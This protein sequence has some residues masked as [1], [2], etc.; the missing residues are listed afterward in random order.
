ME[1]ATLLKARAAADRLLAVRPRS[2]Q[3]LRQRLERRGFPD[4]IVET[5]VQ[6]LTRQGL[7]NDPQFARYV[8][9]SRLL[10]KPV[11][12]RR[13]REQ[14]RRT[15]VP[16]AVAEQ[17]VRAATEGYDEAE[18]ARALAVRRWASLAR[19]PAATGT[20][21]LIGF[22]QR[23]GFQGEVVYRVVREVARGDAEGPA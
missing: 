22:L 16:P 9:T 17:A 5:T 10:S 21:R 7:L 6:A 12:I 14:V 15:G 13:L 23:R 3:E 20:R 18:A 2:E 8:A 19:L 4:T 11:G 1:P